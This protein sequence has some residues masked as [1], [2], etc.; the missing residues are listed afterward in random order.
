MTDDTFDHYWALGRRPGPWVGFDEK[1]EERNEMKT[2][3][4]LFGIECGKGWK[5]L[6]EPL[7]ELCRK[8]GASITQIKEKFGTLRFYVAG[9]T[10]RVHEA[11]DAA[12]R[13]SAET[14]EQCGAPG[15]RIDG[16]WIRTLCAKCAK[17]K[18]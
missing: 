8:D 12:E 13:K 14:C 9:G 5:S 16:G 17:I 1:D 6:Y 15:K 4:E 3:Y 2:P 18:S 10:D 7:I 11:I